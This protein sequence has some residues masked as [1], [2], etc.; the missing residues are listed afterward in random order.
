MI[1]VCTRDSRLQEAVDHTR[2]ALVPVRMDSATADANAD[3][4]HF[5]DVELPRRLHSALGLQAAR[6]VDRQPSLAF[7][8]R[9]GRAYTYTPGSPTIAITHGE[10]AA[11]TVIEFDTAA[12]ADFVTERRSIPSLLY[13]KSLGIP[14]GDANVLFG[15]EPALRALLQER[16]I[17]DAPTLDLRDEDGTPLNLATTFT[18]ASAP[19]AVARFISKAG[20]AVVRGVFSS[21]E[22]A[23]LAT[24]ADRLAAAARQG[25]RRSWWAR[26]ADGEQIL[27]R[28]TYTSLISDAIAAL[29]D[30]FRLRNLARAFAPD[31]VPAPDRL[32]GIA[33]I[34]KNPNVV[35]GLSDLP[36]HIDCG[37][38]GHPTLC[39]VLQITV[40]LDP[41]SEDTGT[42][43]FLAGSHRFVT[44]IPADETGL[45]VVTV[46][47]R[48]GDCLLHLSDTMHAAPPPRGAA[49][50]R[51][52]LVASFYRPSV[53]DVVPPGQGFNDVLLSRDDGH[54]ENL[55]QM[56][57]RD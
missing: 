15:W 18:G 4:E 37:M 35:D 6:D 51:R 49:R 42:L 5:H 32:D 53:L 41:A 20:F 56:T 23:A 7:R 3:F 46:A 31:Y 26:N 52:S 33:L 28:V 29:I 16:P 13:G 9:E 22:I 17:Y 10:R 11:N 19:A 30:D 48:P 55:R 50:Y 43:K 34:I 2:L 12:W 14:R 47:G 1:S 36:W 25:D 40:L 8:L 27:C 24:E 45:P 44:R 39:P 38:G 21:E 54:V 57:A